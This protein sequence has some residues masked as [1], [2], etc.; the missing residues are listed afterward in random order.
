MTNHTFLWRNINAIRAIMHIMRVQFFCKYLGKRFSLLPFQVRI[1]C[2]KAINEMVTG[3]HG[4]GIFHTSPAIN[5]LNFIKSD[6]ITLFKVIY[7]SG[8]ILQLSTVTPK[9][10]QFVCVVA[11]DADHFLLNNFQFFLE[12]F[13]FHF[14]LHY[15]PFCL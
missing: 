15:G 7:T 14:L 6:L 4:Y 2:L 9:R 8:Q 13:N 1:Y 3:F 12:P 10:K 11:H 5:A